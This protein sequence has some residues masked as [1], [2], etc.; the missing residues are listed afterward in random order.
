M[1]SKDTHPKHYYANDNTFDKSTMPVPDI[2]KNKVIHGDSAEVLKQL[3]N[4]CVDLVFTSPPYNFKMDYSTYNDDISFEDYF[5]SLF[6]I[7]DEC[8]RVTKYGGRIAINVCPLWSSY[9]PVHHFITSHLCLHR[10]MIFRDEIIWQKNN[11]E[12]AFSCFGSYLS[13]SSPYMKHTHEYVLVY[14]KGSIKHEVAHE[15]GDDMNEQEFTDWL[16]TGTWSLSCETAMQN[17]DHPAMFPEELAY[18]VLKLYSAKGDMILDP[19]GGIGTTA[20]VAKKTG[21]NYLSIDIDE[22]YTEKAANRVFLTLQDELCGY[23]SITKK[24]DFRRIKF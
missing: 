23:H 13:S 24:C 6:I 12:C 19:F 21:R 15:T 17:Y 14:A 10:K 9:I 1:A 5:R 2:F 18:R 7:L 22:K 4:N 11:R 20:T 3:P 8:V 16:K